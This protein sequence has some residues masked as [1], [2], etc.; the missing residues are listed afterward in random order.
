MLT[1]GDTL[2]SKGLLYA[3]QF[4]YIVSAVE[5]G[6]FSKK[7][8]KVNIALQNFILLKILGL[9]RNFKVTCSIFFFKM[10]HLY[11]VT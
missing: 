7:S 9:V 3:A 6:T 10:I 8:S 5:F 1:L 11:C 2:A 4:C